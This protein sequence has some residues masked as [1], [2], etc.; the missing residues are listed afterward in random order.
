MK[1]AR[2]RT[3]AEKYFAKHP[4]SIVKFVI[5]VYHT[6]T[7]NGNELFADALSGEVQGAI[8]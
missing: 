5:S 1:D 8:V 3:E 2:L 6:G 7:T 4:K